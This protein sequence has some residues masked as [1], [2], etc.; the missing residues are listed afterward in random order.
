MR[1]PGQQQQSAAS[2]GAQAEVPLV[3]RA[4][5]GAGKGYGGSV[6]DNEVGPEGG[7]E[8]VRETVETINSLWA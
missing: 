1:H 2:P 8:L 6:H 7:Q 5:A 3:I 4:S